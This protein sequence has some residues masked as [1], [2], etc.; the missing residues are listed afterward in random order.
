M[1]VACTR[2]PGFTAVKIAKNN[3][4]RRYTAVG[5]LEELPSFLRLLE[6]LL[7]SYFA[8]VTALHEQGTCRYPSDMYMNKNMYM[9]IKDLCTR[10]SYINMSQIQPICTSTLCI[11]VAAQIPRG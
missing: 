3:V 2:K 8:G 7:P 5:I 10:E 11:S 1:L 4:E 6:T 9:F